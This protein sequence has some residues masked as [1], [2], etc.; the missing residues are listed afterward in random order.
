MLE[1]ESLQGMYG[2]Q[3][4]NK[5]ANGQAVNSEKFTIDSLIKKLNEFLSILNSHGVD[6][7]IVNQIFKQVAKIKILIFVSIDYCK[8]T[9]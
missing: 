1:Q 3:Q 8:S 7:E 9:K 4:M 6:P 2:K 5:Q